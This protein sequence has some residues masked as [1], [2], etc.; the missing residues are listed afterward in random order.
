MLP[1]KRKFLPA[2]FETFPPTAAETGPDRG[3][4]DDGGSGE[5]VIDLSCKRRPV[6]PV[7]PGTPE[8]GFRRLQGRAELAR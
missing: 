5:A 6:T 3:A 2:E 7:T 1:K 8:R 4:E